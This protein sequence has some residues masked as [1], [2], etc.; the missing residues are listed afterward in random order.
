MVN[1]AFSKDVVT[2]PIKLD[3]VLRAAGQALIF[4]GTGHT[5]VDWGLALQEHPLGRT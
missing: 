5:V 3:K 1:Q 2:N 4:D